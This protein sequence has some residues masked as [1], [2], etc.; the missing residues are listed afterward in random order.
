MEEVYGEIWIDEW[1]KEHPGDTDVNFLFVLKERIK[2]EPEKVYYGYFPMAYVF[3]RSIVSGIYRQQRELRG[4]VKKAGERRKKIIDKIVD[5]ENKL[6]NERTSRKIQ[7]LREDIDKLNLQVND[8]DEIIFKI[9]EHISLLDE[10]LSALK[11]DF[12]ENIEDILE[13]YESFKN[14]YEN[15]F[16]EEEW[17]YKVFLRERVSEFN[18]KLERILNRAVELKLLTK[19]KNKNDVKRILGV[20]PYDN[21]FVIHANTN[22][23]NFYLYNP[24]KKDEYTAL[25]Y[26]IALLYEDI[27]KIKLLLAIK[28]DPENPQ[29]FKDEISNFLNLC[30]Q[31]HLK[32]NRIVDDIENAIILGL[33]K[34]KTIDE[35]LKNYKIQGL[36]KEEFKKYLSQIYGNLKNLI[37]RRGQLITYEVIPDSTINPFL[38][39]PSEFSN[40]SYT[41]LPKIEDIRKLLPIGFPPYGVFLTFFDAFIQIYEN[42]IMFYTPNLGSCYSIN[43]KIQKKIK[44][45]RE[46][47][48]KG[49]LK[50]TWSS[51]IDE[52][53]ETKGM[54][55]IE[56]MYL[57][58]A[59]VVQNKLNYVE[60]IGISKLQAHI[61]LDDVIRESLNIRFP[62]G[63]NRIWILEEF[64]KNR[65][66]HPLILKY[67]QKR[68]NENNT[69]T[70]NI[71]KTSL[72]ALAVDAKIKEN[73]SIDLFTDEF[74]TKYRD[75]VSDIKETYRELSIQANNILKLFDSREE[76]QNLCYSLMAALKRR[77]RIAFTNILLKKFLRNTEKKEILYL[78]NFIFN[79][80]TTN[81]ISWEN[82]A[83]ALVV[84]IW[85]YG[86]EKV[87]ESV[88]EE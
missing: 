39:S 59:N 56:N 72:C 80:I 13:N 7:K 76:K 70:R 66:L 67:V 14:Q 17:I 55:S 37:N 71:R 88:A 69:L 8:L 32:P 12:K 10:N 5:K 9:N 86:G 20:L 33:S 73:N 2:R 84:G 1:K 26:V 74:F 42:S 79:R 44:F 21:S 48:K 35:V 40:I 45:V 58:E 4:L 24:P 68:I 38:F 64:I 83:L 50:I 28:Y 61:I 6:K 15:Y 23:R 31:N 57:L 54:F 41:S 3:R 18:K 82:Y 81:D 49:I 43:K 30:K 16:I 36:S 25:T 85:S 62:Q 27:E 11:R 52:L 53:I 46:G 78:T 63:D 77:N 19:T 51:I 47:K 22:E 29:T 75:I 34:K 60:Y 87:G 65:P